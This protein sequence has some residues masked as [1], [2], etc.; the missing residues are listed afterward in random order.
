M[1]AEQGKTITSLRSTVTWRVVNNYMAIPD[2]ITL[3]AILV[4]KNFN[5]E[6]KMR[7]KFVT[8][9][10]NI[11]YS[12]WFY[13]F[14]LDAVTLFISFSNAVFIYWF[15]CTDFAA[16]NVT[17]LLQLKLKD[18]HT[19]QEFRFEVKDPIQKLEED[20]DCKELVLEFAAIRPDLSPLQGRWSTIGS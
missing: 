17:V 2:I 9:G 7:N 4:H 16:I 5:F 15:D 20:P 12:G 1:D 6:K 19:N 14:S 3:K 11:M 10:Y 13:H 18:R 8:L